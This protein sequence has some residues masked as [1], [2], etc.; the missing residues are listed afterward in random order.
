MRQYWSRT[1]QPTDAFS[2]YV[3]GGLGLVDD[4]EPGEI[5]PDEVDPAWVDDSRESEDADEHGQVT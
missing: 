4:G 1:P 5:F 3:P 2:G